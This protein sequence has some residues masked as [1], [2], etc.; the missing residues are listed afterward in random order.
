MDTPQTEP[1]RSP[2]SPRRGVQELS[3][4]E[5]VAEILRK[6]R[7]ATAELVARHADD[8]YGY[9]RRRLAPQTDLIDDIVQETFLAAWDSLAT[10]QS[11][12][13]LRIWLLGIARHKVEDYYRA[14][15]RESEQWADDDGATAEAVHCPDPM[16]ELSSHDAGRHAR[17]ILAELPEHY[18]L[19]LAWRYWQQRTVRQMA[20]ETGRSEKAVERL[21]ARARTA[22]KKRWNER[23]SKAE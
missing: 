1:P 2:P 10:F 8:V 18:G 16:E 11:Q 7:K 22:F 4:G 15:L 12:A 13:P 9:V 6:D 19:I 17:A 5:L 14:R 20:V 23:R 3:D 21:L